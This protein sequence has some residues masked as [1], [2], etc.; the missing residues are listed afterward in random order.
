MKN[1][2][3]H[4]W[5]RSLFPITEI[6]LDPLYHQMH[7]DALRN[8]KNRRKTVT[9]QIIIYLQQQFLLSLVTQQ[10]CS[11]TYWN[12]IFSVNILLYLCMYTIH[13]MCILSLQ[14]MNINTSPW[15]SMNERVI[16]EEIPISGQVVGHSQICG[17]DR[18]PNFGYFQ[19]R[20]RSK[21]GE[22][23]RRF[24]FGI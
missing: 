23:S 4:V 14:Q 1:V 24:M 21:L 12:T 22:S 13:Y 9:K 19:I 11:C 2:L 7:N 18:S 3:I 10:Y 8:G 17:A 20:R 16:Y 15:Q 5:E 6:V